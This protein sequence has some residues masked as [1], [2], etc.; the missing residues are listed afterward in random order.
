MSDKTPLGLK[1][2]ERIFGL[3]VIILGVVMAYYTNANASAAGVVGSFFIYV[4]FC[5]IVIGILFF[6][7]KMFLVLVI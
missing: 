2:G 1:F 4:G 7:M 6:L 5:L 3:L